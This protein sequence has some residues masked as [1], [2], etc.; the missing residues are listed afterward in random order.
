MNRVAHF[1]VRALCMVAILFGVAQR[2]AEAQSFPQGS[3]GWFTVMNQQPGYYGATPADACQ[4][5][6]QAYNA[7]AKSVFVAA[8]PTSNPNT[9]QCDWTK[10]Y[11]R[12]NGGINSCGTIGP[13]IVW[14]TCSAGYTAVGGNCSP[15]EQITPPLPPGCSSSKSTSGPGIG[16]APNPPLNSPN[17]GN[18]I[19]IF[20]GAKLEEETDFETAGDKGRLYVSRFYRSRAP[21]AVIARKGEVRGSVGGW[22]FNFL[23]EIHLASD[24]SF[25]QYIYLKTGVTLYLPNGLALDFA[26]S[27]NSF[28]PSGTIQTRYSL[29]FVGTPPSD[30]TQITYTPTQWRLIDADENRVWTFQT[31]RQINSSDSNG[32]PLY[33]IA[34]P[35]SMSE[36]QYVWNF[37]YDQYGALQSITDSYGM[38]LAVAW[39]YFQYPDTSVGNT[40]PVPV[41]IASITPSNGTSLVYTYDPPLQSG[42]SVMNVGRLVQKQLIAG[43]SVLDYT[44]Y[45]YENALFPTFLT[46]VTD[47]RGVRYGTFAYDGLGRATSTQHAGGLDNYSI[48]YNQPS[49]TLPNDLVRYVTN[50]L[51]K[52]AEYHWTHPS[53]S[54]LSTLTSVVGEPSTNCVGTTRGWTYDSNYFVASETDEEGRV[55]AYVRDAKNR[56]TSITR[57]YGTSQAVTTNVAWHATLNL[58]T[59]IAVPGQ[60][61]SATYNAGGLVTQIQQLDTTTQSVPYSTSGQTRTWSYVYNS[62]GQLTSVTDP[63]GAVTAYAYNANGGLQSVTDPVGNVTTVTSWNSLR[64]PTSLTDPNGVVVNLAYEQTH[65][66]LTSLTADAAGT[67][68]ITTIAYDAVGDV[69]KITLPNGAYETYSYDGARR[70]MSVA[71]SAG[72]TISY[73]RNANGDTTSTSVSGGVGAG[74]AET[75]VFDELGRVIKSIGAQSQA[76][77]F[78][79]DRTD[80]LVSVADPRS[81]VFSYGFDALNRLNKEVDESGATVNLARDGQDNITGYQD[82]RANVTSYV[83]NGFGEVI[84]EVSPDRGATTYVRDAGGRVTQRT[85]PRGIVTNYSYDAAGRISYKSY[86]G[87]P[88]SQYGQGFAWDYTGDGNKGAGRLVGLYSETGNDWLVYDAQGRVTVD[89]R[90]TSPAPSVAV[91]Y[92][93]DAAGNIVSMTYPSG[94]TV[95][96]GRDAIGRISSI[97]TRQNSAAQDQAILWLAQ[98]NPYGPLASMSFNNGQTTNFTL[99]SS[100]RVKRVQTGWSA[101]PSGSVDLNLSWT[102]DMVDSI[103]DNNNPGTS[104]PFTYGAQSQS[105]TYTPTRRLASASGYYGQYSWTYDGVGNRLTETG[106]G[107]LS[108]YLYPLGSNRLQSVATGSSTRS[109]GYDAAGDVASDSSAAGSNIAMNYS[110]DVEGRLAK[111]SRAGAP[112][113]GG[114]YG[115]DA[116]N[117][118]VSRTVTSGATTTTTLY[119][120]DTHNHIIAELDSAGVTHREYIWLNDL[121]VAVVDQVNTSTPQVYMVHTDHL[122]RPVL[123]ISTAGAWVWNAIY[124][125]FGAVSYIWSSPAV[126]DIRFPGQ[127]FQLET[128]LAYNWH[129]HYDASLGRYLQPDPIG[130]AGGR[131]LYGYVGG[132]PLAYGDPDG[133]NPSPILIG[134]EIG[135]DIGTAILPGAGTIIGAAAGGLAGAGV[136]WGVLDWVSNQFCSRKRETRDDRYQKCLRAAEG[137]EDDWV[138]FCDTI[139]KKERNN[140]VGG[141]Q[142]HMACLSHTFNS[143]QEKRN[144]CENQ[145]GDH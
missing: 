77:G 16:S 92:S 50:P 87:Y 18:P 96:F 97:T 85:D 125:P 37:S 29:Q 48:A 113:N 106:N 71:N 102:G 58:P 38:S 53:N 21:S 7:T 130:Y 60:T 55:I 45:Q 132:N 46:G 140:V 57:G 117:R 59:Q 142:A 91:Y 43:G 121:P 78:A 4:H 1:A 126:M 11:D 105:F 103:V 84:Q 19:A 141:Q 3:Q 73:A 133:R 67:P 143:V 134:G 131:S 82:P 138:A 128:G 42:A 144:W 86:N 61:I 119:V 13:T 51:G 5:Q 56:P 30:W 17:A 62:T 23:S 12:C 9:Y 34:R 110:Y 90:T 75:R 98:W 40:N 137:G 10:F 109:L 6:W 64:Q 74:F 72:E 39:N 76:Y 135:A 32:A 88:A 100:Y 24:T 101:S 20:D 127:W 31:F 107:V 112:S 115:Y 2:D 123:M 14:L 104:P 25:A 145:Y 70:L 49:T 33:L 65:G 94:R 116:L 26:Q 93:Y 89:Y 99:D 35:I 54:Y 120:H 36:G 124:N 47:A 111:A 22:R 79:Y 81:N 66:W 44:T 83:R 108:S 63:A 80:N 28:V 114:S 118:L 69:T 136:S 139:S 95:N 122:G 68:A 8:V 15:N 129:R 52:V 41:S 27:G